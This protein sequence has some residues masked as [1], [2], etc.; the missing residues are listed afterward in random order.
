MYA[1]NSL[2][3]LTTIKCILIADLQ[4]YLN[5]LSEEYNLGQ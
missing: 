2:I 3:I 4:I 1:N 5:T